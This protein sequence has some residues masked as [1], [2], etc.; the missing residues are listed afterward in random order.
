MIKKG[1]SILFLLFWIFSQTLS[2]RNFI[3][4]AG[5][6]EGDTGYKRILPVQNTL[7][8]TQDKVLAA[9]EDKILILQRIKGDT[10]PQKIWQWS[11]SDTKSQ[12]PKAYQ[13]YYSSMDECK[14]VSGG[15]ILACSSGGGVILIDI[16]TKKC[17]FYAYCPMAHS[18]EM[19]PNNRIA[20]ALSTVDNG[21]AV[22][23]Y[24]AGE[25]NVCLFSDS[26]YSGHGLVWNAAQQRLYALGYDSIRCY[27]LSNWERAKPSLSLEGRWALPVVN[28]HDLT[29]INDTKI[30]VTIAKSNSVYV[31]DTGT[32]QFTA[33]S[34]L[35]NGTYEIKSCNLLPPSGQCIYTQAETSWWSNHIYS[36]NPEWKITTT[37][38]EKLY[39]ARIYTE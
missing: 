19:L 36:L 6:G 4:L 24:N 12:L 32:H 22:K 35:H 9:G 26:L 7:M 31:F 8:G 2:A 20:V 28:G 34:P 37:N 27:S 15:K 39:K 23:I 21:N 18:V 16:A 38:V 10:I 5:S 3:P 25:S 17:L 33:Y 11:L 1:I 13:S 30:M 14:Q 29:L